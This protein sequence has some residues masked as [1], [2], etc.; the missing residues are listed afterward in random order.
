M[1]LN[2]WRIIVLVILF[3]IWVALSIGIYSAMVDA[4]MGAVWQI[5]VALAGWWLLYAGIARLLYGE[6]F[7]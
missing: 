2:T 6:I 1:A 3:V 4:N 5:I 7:P